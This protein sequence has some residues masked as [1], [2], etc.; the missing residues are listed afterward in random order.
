MVSH[1]TLYAYYPPPSRIPVHPHNPKSSLSSLLSPLDSRLSAL[2]CPLSTLDLAFAPLPP[3]VMIVLAS[4]RRAASAERSRAER[5]IPAIVLLLLQLLLLPL[6]FI[7][8][9]HLLL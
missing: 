1:E 9:R 2:H 8:P 4:E 7:M 5:S 3:L 6:T